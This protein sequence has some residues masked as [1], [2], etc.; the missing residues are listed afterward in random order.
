MALFKTRSTPFIP[1]IATRKY[2]FIKSS[3]VMKLSEQELRKVLSGTLVESAK[4]TLF[5]VH[6]T[7]AMLAKKD[8]NRKIEYSTSL[9]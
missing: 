3:V 6:I 8:T 5:C 4:F 2:P 7:R 9:L 1:K